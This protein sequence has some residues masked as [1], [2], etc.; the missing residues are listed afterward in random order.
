[1]LRESK[2]CD[3]ATKRR[4]QRED[5]CVVCGTMALILHNVWGPRGMDRWLA[6]T[7]LM[8]APKLKHKLLFCNL[9][10][11][12]SADGSKRFAS[13]FQIQ[14]IFFLSLSPLCDDWQFPFF[15]SFAHL[16]IDVGA[17]LHHTSTFNLFPFLRRERFQTYE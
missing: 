4:E 11:L 6:N 9:P 1:M 12:H 5:V 16:F 10:I 14:N 15:P 3:M 2:G 17:P 13:F 7:I 8:M